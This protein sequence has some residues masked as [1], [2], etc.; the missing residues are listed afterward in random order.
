MGL[1]FYSG[2]DDAYLEFRD[3]LL[4][5][6]HVWLAPSE[7]ERDDVVS[8]V[9]FFLDWRYR[10]STGVLDE[11]TS[12]ELAEFLV[13]W[14]PR[15]LTGRTDDAVNLCYAV[16]V[17]V[18]FM[19][20]TER[21]AGGVERAARLRRTVDDLAPTV[22]AETRDPTPEP[23]GEQ[24]E[25]FELPFA[26]VPPPMSDVEEAAADAAL[27]AKVTALRHYLGPD[28]KELTDEG[29]LQAAD[30]R[31]LVESLDTGD[32]RCLNFVL[33]VAVQA[34]AVGVQQR[35]VVPLPGW[36]ARPAV[37][38]AAALFVAILEVGPLSSQCSGDQG[39]SDE[40]LHLFDA[41]IVHWLVPLLAPDADEQPFESL[42]EWAE[43][44]IAPR[45]DQDRPDDADEVE[46]FTE[47]GVARVL[48]TLE[49]AGV[50]RWTDGV[51]SP[52]P[53]GPGYGTGG[54]VSLTALGRHLLPDYLEGAGYAPRRDSVAEAGGAELIDAMLAADDAQREALVAGW[55][56]DR[57]VV[58]RVRMLTEAIAEAPSAASRLMGFVAL[59][60][61]DIDVVEPLVRQ[62]LDTP[63]A[64]HAALWLMSVDRADA[65]T[66]GSLVDTA[67]LVD[68]LA[69]SVDD[70]KELCTLFGAAQEPLR[71]LENMWRHPAPETAP[72]LDALG[73]HL[74]DRTLAKAARK[75][76][77][78]HR[79][80]IANRP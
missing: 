32:L 38:R 75:A 14:C 28:G 67:V 76:A 26:S 40:L 53:F 18:D 57:P 16:G 34:G 9:A 73:R 41:G 54:S 33:D 4:D 45:L 11:F 47:E 72:V 12:D 1:R 80:W 59:H 49:D 31:A 13:D 25:L 62:L 51:E 74:P 23:S 63:V 6:L 10:E 66:L 46:A 29:N 19:A 69:G 35:R 8:D 65:E 64:G 43:L 48:H 78:R 27:L 5:E 60:M 44:T 21:L 24:A 56:A 17:Y 71:L 20:A 68:V 42:V 77:V 30:G 3:A 52:R 39:H 36:E 61:F 22:L 50:A 2:D 70:P 58:E 79:S 37:A 7:P 15:R 55:Q